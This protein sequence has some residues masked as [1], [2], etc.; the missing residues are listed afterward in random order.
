M[1]TTRLRLRDFCPADIDELHALHND[2]EVMRLLTGGAPVSRAEIEREYHDRFLAYDYWAV[3]DRATGAFFG[4]V[5]LHASRVGGVT[6]GVAD[7]PGDTWLGY[8]LHRRA[9]GS[10]YA[11]EASRTIIDAGFREHGVLRVRAT[12]MAVNTRSRRVM[13]RVGLRYVRTYHEEWDDPLPGTERGEV[14]YAL[15]R[16]EWAS[17]GNTRS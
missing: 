2:P 16:A 10:G 5:G 15:T 8:R 9:W 7:E 1:E 14:E 3:T 11:V 13:E 17:R 12:T 6:G 4:W